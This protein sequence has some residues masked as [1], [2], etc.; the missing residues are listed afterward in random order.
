MLLLVEDA[1]TTRCILEQHF[2]RAGCDVLQAA[3]PDTA[4]MRL[5]AASV[6]MVILDL[7]LGA[8]RSGLEVLEQMRLQERYVSVPVVILTAVT[9]VSPEEQ[10]I[11]ERLGAQLL[12]K[13]Q[14]FREIVQ[15][16]DDMLGR[17][18][19]A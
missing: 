9:K 13:W 7:R 18:A 4:L 3:D 12:Y 11:I 15:Q 8:D 1:L 14:G 5:K 6:D 10:E 16:L 2:A 17:R 19:A